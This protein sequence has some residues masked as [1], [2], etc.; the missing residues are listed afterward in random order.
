MS[1]YEMA[2]QEP[3]E[4]LLGHELWQERQEAVRRLGEAAMCLHSIGAAF[5]QAQADGNIPSE[6]WSLNTQAQLRHIEATEWLL[7]VNK[8]IREIGL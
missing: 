6:L 4:E 2:H 3:S 8:R 1:N 7:E 5:G